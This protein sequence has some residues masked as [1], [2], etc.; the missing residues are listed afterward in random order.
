MRIYKWILGGEL[1]PLIVLTLI[2][3]PQA[4]SGYKEEKIMNH[5]VSFDSQL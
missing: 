2:P 1:K 3:K 5:K 4:I